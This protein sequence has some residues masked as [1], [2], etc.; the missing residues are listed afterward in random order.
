MI[1]HDSD[2][3][4]NAWHISNS[5]IRELG[6]RGCI[7]ANRA[8]TKCAQPTEQIHSMWNSSRRGRRRESVP[9]FDWTQ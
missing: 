8:D 5:F 2:F 3:R 9:N 4:R 7:A 6:P 1:F